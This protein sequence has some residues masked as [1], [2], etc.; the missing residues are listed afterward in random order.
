MHPR[1]PYG[2]AKTYGHFITRNYRESFN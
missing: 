1:S 2:V